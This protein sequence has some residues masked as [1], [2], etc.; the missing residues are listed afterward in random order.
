[1]FDMRGWMVLRSIASSRVL[2]FVARLVVLSLLLIAWSSIQFSCA[3]LAS[4]TSTDKIIFISQ[5]KFN[6]ARVGYIPASSMEAGGWPFLTWLPFSCKMIDDMIIGP[7]GYIYIS[8]TYSNQIIRVNTSGTEKTVVMDKSNLYP[9][10]LAFDSEGNLIFTTRRKNSQSATQGVWQV[11]GADP[12]NPP[13]CIIPSTAFQDDFP[14]LCYISTGVYSGDLLLI[15]AK[16]GAVARAIAPDFKDIVTF[17]PKD[18]VKNPSDAIVLADGSIL[19]SDFEG[20]KVLHFSERGNLLETFT[21]TISRPNKMHVDSEGIIYIAD[22]V[23]GGRSIQ[24]LTVWTPEG[25]NI[26]RMPIEAIHSIAVWEPTPPNKKPHAAFIVSPSNPTSGILAKFYGSSSSDSDG[27]IGSFKWNFGDGAT[28]W[29][30]SVTHA[31]THSGTFTVTLTVTDDD[32]ASDSTSKTMSVQDVNTPPEARFTFSP[33]NP[34]TSS[35]VSLNGSTSSDSDGTISTFKWNFGDGST[36]E[37]K[38]VTHRFSSPGTYIVTLNV[39]DDDGERVSTSKTITVRAPNLLPVASFTWSRSE[40]TRVV[41]ESRNGDLIGFDASSC[42]DSDGW[43]TSYAWDWNSDGIY[44]ETPNDPIVEHQ[45][46]TSAEHQVTLQVTDNE[47]ATAKVTKIFSAPDLQP[48]IANFSFDHPERSILDDVKFAD[49]SSDPDGKVV[50]WSWNFGDGATSTLKDPTHQY[51]QKGTY[52]VVLTVTDNDHLTGTK[53]DSITVVN[54]PPE[55]RF[56]FSP[57][58]PEVGV[59]IEF[60]ASES[61]DPDGEITSYFWDFDGKGT[62]DAEGMVVSWSF[63]EEGS[64]PVFLTVMDR[65]GIEIQTEME[66]LV[67]SPQIVKPRQTW[68]VVIGIS[69]YKSVR[70]ILAYPEDDAKAFADFLT[71]QAELPIDHLT[72]LLG[73]EATLSNILAAMHWLVRMSG[74]DDLAIFYFAGHGGFWP[75]D[76]GDEEDG[77]DEFTIP[78]DANKDAMEATCLRD[79]YF[80]SQ[81]MDKLRRKHVLI[82]L[83]SCYS[84]GGTRGARALQS[85]F[86]PAVGKKADIFNDFAPQGRLVLAAAAEDQVAIEYD[87]LKHGVFTYFLLRGLGDV[88]LPPSEG[89]PPV[90]SAEADQNGNGKVTVYELYSYLSQEI[91]DYTRKKGSQQDPQLVGEGKR[92][93][94]LPTINTPPQ[95]AFDWEPSLP[96]L[97]KT[98]QFTDAS[99]DPDGTVQGWQWDFGDGAISAEQNPTH[100]YESTGMYTVTLRVEDDQHATSEKTASISVVPSPPPI[101]DFSCLPSQPWATEDIRFTDRSHDPDGDVVAWEWN[102]GDG[103]TSTERN[104]FHSYPYS[105]TYTV[106]LKVQDNNGIWSNPKPLKLEVKLSSYVKGTPSEGQNPNLYLVWVAPDDREKA[107]VGAMIEVFTRNISS[108]GVFYNSFAQGVVIEVLS[109]EQILIEVQ[110]SV[111]EPIESGMFVRFY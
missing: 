25:E 58:R 67:G 107:A 71:E 44:D 27:T 96:L 61:C 6:N 47:G 79:D 103:G 39:T 78:Y 100:V 74:P 64:Y 105:G 3:V 53:P 75:D 30:E 91:A 77:V 55:A 66:V 70:P 41:V 90:E 22:S 86:R 11:E 31:F 93:V 7:D 16:G 12:S 33:A 23:Y 63:P 40:G 97:G 21:T 111:S 49:K 92:G 85:G 69:E 83:D 51:S 101:A 38:Y 82:I 1:M 35:G 104:P 20:S 68:A 59:G 106:V 80:G 102:F 87:A 109:A 14:R 29:G 50:A 94:E 46:A 13:E 89:L 42:S 108:H 52:T 110:P 18:Q 15:G 62:I 2:R 19:V 28:A 65:E 24:I 84:G 56:T 76:N 9:S 10:D 36:G 4:G 26:F 57:E 48:P 43:I 17:I 81:F 73:A 34:D 99:K 72:V 88:T 8:D 95:V 37:G 54:T 32:G 98:V 60:D 5:E 45:F